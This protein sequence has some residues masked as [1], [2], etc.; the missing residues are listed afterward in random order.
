MLLA[1]RTITSAKLLRVSNCT[2]ISTGQDERPFFINGHSHQIVGP[3]AERIYMS[4]DDPA[5]CPLCHVS[6]RI[7]TPIGSVVL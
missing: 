6:T 4:L 5:L 2:T 7:N 1:A 3:V